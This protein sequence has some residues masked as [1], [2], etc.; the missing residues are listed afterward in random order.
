MIT[1]ALFLADLRKEKEYLSVPGNQVGRFEEFFET[2]RKFAECCEAES[3]TEV[4]Q[5]LD[6]VL[7]RLGVSP[8]HIEKLFA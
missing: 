4:R 7:D 6:S 1:E 5:I 3:V 8:D 2:V